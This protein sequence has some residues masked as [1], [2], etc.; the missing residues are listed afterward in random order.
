MAGSMKPRADPMLVWL[1]NV[2]SNALAAADFTLPDA[3]VGERCRCTCGDARECARGDA[4]QQK[5]E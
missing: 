1:A 5:R 2:L 3:F 4:R